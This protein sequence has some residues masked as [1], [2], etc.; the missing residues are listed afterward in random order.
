MDLTA[1]GYISVEEI[2]SH[3]DNC[4]GGSSYY[5]YPVE[6]TKTVHHD[7]VYEDRTITDKEAW[8]EYLYTECTTCGAIRK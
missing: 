2:S 5:G 3:V 6:V 1:A 8:D 4:K 7:A